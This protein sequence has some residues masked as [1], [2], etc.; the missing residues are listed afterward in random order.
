M[1]LQGSRKCPE[2]LQEKELMPICVRLC[3]LVFN[4]YHFIYIL[5]ECGENA[6]L[7]PCPNRCPPGRACIAVCI[8]ACECNKGYMMNFNGDCVKNTSNYFL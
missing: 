2:W 4:L 6:D 3:C 5:D 1:K 8:P 7:N